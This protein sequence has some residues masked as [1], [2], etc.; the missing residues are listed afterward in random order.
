MGGSTKPA[1]AKAT[2]LSVPAVHKMAASLVDVGLLY[3]TGE[4]IS[5]GHGRKG[6]VIGLNPTFR[7]AI[8]IEI[9]DLSITGIVLDFAGQVHQEQAIGLSSLQPN[10]VL[11]TVIRMIQDL[12][13]A[14]R[15][16]GPI[17][18]VGIG[19]H[20]I[21]EK[22]RITRFPGNPDWEPLAITSLVQEATGLPCRLDLRI[23]AATVSELRFGRR[24]GFPGPIFY[25]N[26]GPGNGFATGII[27]HD[28]VL[29]GANGLQGQFHH[30][31]MDPQGERCY[32]GSF[33]CLGTLT[34]PQAIQQQ[35]Q[36][37]LTQTGVDSAL[38]GLPTVDFS[39]ILAAA[40]KHDKL[41]RHL[42]EDACTWLGIGF[43]HVINLLNP[44]L[45][46]IGGAYA[47]GGEMILHAIQRSAYRY[48]ESH[49]LQN[50]Q[51]SLSTLNHNAAATG[52]ATLLFDRYFQ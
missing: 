49:L 48:S 10:H 44:S 28:Q 7:T 33:G 18:G 4:E 52:A 41:A 36:E 9:T 45:I 40:H 11:A 22:G 39:S 17:A 20:G 43:S 13:E 32:C 47:E 26:S 27:I 16:L 19:T 2:G 25:F 38:R 6:R 29:R 15:E 31:H 14:A 46:V 8:G 23:Y 24:Y 12:Q 30:L 50:L 1:L 35:A 51:W 37:A 21:A 3:E 34:S 42:I 5:S